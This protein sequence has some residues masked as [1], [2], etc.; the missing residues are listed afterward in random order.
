MKVWAAQD[1]LPCMKQNVN[2]RRQSV[3][4]VAIKV[5]LYQSAARCYRV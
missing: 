5:Y 3:S 1:Q 2:R 4:A